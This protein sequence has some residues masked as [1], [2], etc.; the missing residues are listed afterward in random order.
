MAFLDLSLLLLHA[1]LLVLLTFLC[2]RCLGRLYRMKRFF[3]RQLID[4]LVRR[5]ESNSFSTSSPS[6]DSLVMAQMRFVIPNECEG[7]KTDFSL[8]SKQGFLAAPEMTR[9]K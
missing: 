9:D 7:S 2:W 6:R 8:R 5:Y 1:F 3:P 4:T